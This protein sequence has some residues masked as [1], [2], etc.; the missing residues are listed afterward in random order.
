MKKNFARK[1]MK[2]FSISLIIFS[3][4]GI[5][6]KEKFYDFLMVIVRGGIFKTLFFNI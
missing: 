3:L 1:L 6:K 2:S 5:E 4:S